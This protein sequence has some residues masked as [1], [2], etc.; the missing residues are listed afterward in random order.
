[1]HAIFRDP[2]GGDAIVRLPEA[3]AARTEAGRCS[4]AARSVGGGDSYVV[5]LPQHRGLLP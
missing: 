4:F 5:R 3:R 2:E 1:M